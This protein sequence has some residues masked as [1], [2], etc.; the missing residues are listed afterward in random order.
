MR[1]KKI[2]PVL[3]AP[4]ES[5]SSSPHPENRSI[6]PSKDEVLELKVNNSGSPIRG[7]LKKGI[8]SGFNDVQ[9]CSSLNKTA[10]VMT[11][12]SQ[13]LEA[14]AAC[15]EK[16]EQIRKR[17]QDLMS[18]KAPQEL[19]QHISEQC[20][21]CDALIESK[22]SFVELIHGE[23]KAVD[24]DY[25]RMFRQQTKDVDMLVISMGTQVIELH[26]THIEELCTIENDFQAQRKD[27]LMRLIKRYM[28]SS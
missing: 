1:Q 26:N 5:A 14:D 25:H 15:K 28:R 13:I 23:L 22:K 8:D 7:T 2:I 21:A 12:E 17:W 4:M 18:C 3:G 19:A 20:K 11:M 6:S 9:I 10:A 16:L 24:E 27:L